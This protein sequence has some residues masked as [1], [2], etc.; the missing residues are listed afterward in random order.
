M[1]IQKQLEQAIID[2]KMEQAELSLL[3]GVAKSTLYLLSCGKG[4]CGNSRTAD[5]IAEALG[6]EWKL[7][8][9]NP[10]Q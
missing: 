5:K 2:A 6:L 7:V 4:R 8:K 9:K 1:T 3:A 10:K